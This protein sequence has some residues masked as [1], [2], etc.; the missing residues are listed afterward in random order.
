MESCY[1][2]TVLSHMTIPFTIHLVTTKPLDPYLKKETIDQI[3]QFLAR[4]NRDYS[5]FLESSFV[6]QHPQLGQVVPTFLLQNQEYQ[7]IFAQCLLMQEKSAGIFDPF[8]SG[9]YDPTGLVKGWAIEEAFFRYLQPLLDTNQ[10]I[11]ASING[12]G[13]MQV[14]AKEQVDFSWKIGIEHPTKTGII[15][16]YTLKNGAIATSGN[17]K[18]GQHVA[19]GRDLRQQVTVL[20]PYLSLADCWATV[21]LATDDQHF[22][23]FIKQEK[24]TGIV[25]LNEHHTYQFQQ[26]GITYD[27]QS[28]LSCE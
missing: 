18:R 28:S 25:Y 14:G 20:A 1:D 6:R 16:T 11:A 23:T 4:I 21:G 15:A 26:G 2:I 24:L 19:S 5:P 9:T 10:L 12:G 22:Q 8:Y 27:T 3:D 13:D 7:A 17:T